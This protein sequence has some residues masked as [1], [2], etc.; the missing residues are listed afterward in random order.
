[1]FKAKS[2]PFRKERQEFPKTVFQEKTKSKMFLFSQ[3]LN[4]KMLVFRVLW[5]QKNRAYHFFSVNACMDFAQVVLGKAF[6][7]IVKKLF[8]SLNTTVLLLCYTDAA[9]TS[10]ICS[11]L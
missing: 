10:N 8:L 9:C 3:Y 5:Y 7:Y 1:M 4:N 11:K 2:F 6:N